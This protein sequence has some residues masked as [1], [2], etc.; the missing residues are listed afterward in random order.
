MIHKIKPEIKAR[1]KLNP[2]YHVVMENHYQNQTEFGELLRVS[3]EHYREPS[4]QQYEDLK[5]DHYKVFSKSFKYEDLLS[6]KAMEPI[7]ET[8]Y[9]PA[10]VIEALQ[11]VLNPSIDQSIRDY[12]G[13]NY[14][15]IW[16]GFRKV[17]LTT[18]NV[19]AKWHCDGGPATHMKT[20]TYF[21]SGSDHGSAT[22]VIDVEITDMLKEVGYVF[23]DINERKDNID[24]L[25]TEIGAEQRKKSL[26]LNAG[27]T[28]VF[29]AFK[30]IHKAGLPNPN[31]FREC[32]DLC[33][34]PSPLPWQEVIECGILPAKGCVPFESYFSRLLNLSKSKNEMS[35][36]ASNSEPQNN[37]LQ[38]MTP[39]VFDSAGS[40]TTIEQVR[41]ILRQI[42]K[43]S[44][45][46][47][48]LSE[49][50]E[51]VTKGYIRFKNPLQFLELLKQSIKNE[52]DWKN[53]FAP[54]ERNRILN[55]LNFEE[56]YF[57][58][59]RVYS[60]VNKPNPEAV[61]W[62]IP[63]HPKHP[64][65]KYDMLPYVKKHA[66]FN[67]K[68]PI[69]S[70][71]SCFAFEIARVLQDQKFNYVISERADNPSEGVFVDGYTAGDEFV[72]FSANYGIL[73][74]TPSLYQLAEKAFSLREFSPYLIKMENGGYMD[75]YRENVYFKSP[76]AFTNDY[77]KHYAAI[78]HS[79]LNAEAF[80]F[81]A[82]LNEC[83]QLYDGSVISRNPREGFSHMINHRTLTVQENVD[84][85]T[86]FF[87]EV[88]K[89]NPKFKMILTLSPIPLLAT[90]RAETHH[91][92]EANI[93]SKAVLRVAIDEV[94]Q[95]NE[96]IFYLP[97]YELVNECIEKPWLPDHRHVTPETVE[98]VV[99]M[100]KEMFFV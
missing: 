74:N 34:L 49:Q 28:I 73:F 53:F 71:G 54:N 65:C 96:D 33:I 79:L 99:K 32:F 60:P 1:Y 72:K 89:R 58:S 25:L 5:T 95:N 64:K 35:M 44:N 48:F 57:N 30:V 98:T 36:V 50:I 31:Q 15:V 16:F 18:D 88:K 14:A 37:N 2:N 78:R 56:K 97:S 55:I 47:N 27:D 51:K 67:K 92:L 26:F 24:D 87:K 40:I 86:N 52:F 77:P 68:T 94:V 91:I 21:N 45:Y 10:R 23:C 20:I 81:T 39:L 62:P 63:D 9:T 11:Q 100:F 69:A 13:S 38:G 75:P 70:A 43:D 61:F 3:R 17:E 8:D 7:F 29:N 12:F 84:Y 22:D 42:F 82:G 76:E 4:S 41:H 90:G 59:T 66:L 83:W 85:M 46:A 93:H 6:L 19:S 80:I